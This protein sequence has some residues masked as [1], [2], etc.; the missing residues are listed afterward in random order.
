MTKANDERMWYLRRCYVVTLEGRYVAAGWTPP[1]WQ[2]T[3]KWDAIR[4]RF[5]R[6]GLIEPDEYG[7]HRIT[8]AGL[9]ALCDHRGQS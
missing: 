7:C 6:D 5:E 9:R 4:A 1:V 3:K 2:G 8:E